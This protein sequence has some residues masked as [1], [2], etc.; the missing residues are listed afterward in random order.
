[1]HSYL[2]S[3]CDGA[4]AHVGGLGSHE[5][6]GHHRH[7]LSRSL[8]FLCNQHVLETALVEGHTAAG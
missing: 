5:I 3:L 2:A 4:A 7:I 8:G 1:M 6:S